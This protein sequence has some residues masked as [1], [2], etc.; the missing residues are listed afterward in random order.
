[1]QAAQDYLHIKAKE[2][3]AKLIKGRS[4]HQAIDGHEANFAVR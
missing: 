2:T 1:M 3:M 4:S